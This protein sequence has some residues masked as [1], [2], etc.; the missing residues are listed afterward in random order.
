MN[1]TE[2]HVHAG[3]F[4][5]NL[6]TM[7]PWNKMMSQRVC[8]HRCEFLGFIC[9]HVSGYFMQSK[10]LSGLCQLTPWN[11]LHNFVA[12][13]Q[14]RNQCE[15]RVVATSSYIMNNETNELP[16]DE[17]KVASGSPLRSDEDEREGSAGAEICSDRE[18]VA[19]VESPPE[20]KSE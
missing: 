14:K 3:H 16:D 13:S 4:V 6:C 5:H 19:S 11:S 7:F 12:L 17:E 18:P 1:E 15:Q 2:K 9:W 8:T 10:P 20:E